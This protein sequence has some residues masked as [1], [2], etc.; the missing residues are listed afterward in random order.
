MYACTVMEAY[1][2]LLRR[3]CQSPAPKISCGNS[4]SATSIASVEDDHLPYDE[5]DGSVLRRAIFKAIWEHVSSEPRLRILTYL[6]S[7]GKERF[8]AA[9]E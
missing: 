3:H 4:G 8:F 7:S 1:T 6:L 2:L 5:N 9:Q